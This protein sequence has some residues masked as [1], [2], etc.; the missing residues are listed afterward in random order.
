MF[1]HQIEEI[2]ECS[3]AI[4]AAQREVSKL[5]EMRQEM[6]DIENMIAQYSDRVQIEGYVLKSQIARVI[7]W[8]KSGKYAK[9]D[10][11]KE[12]S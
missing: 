7:E 10:S 5:R 4:E 12:L 11:R 8:T 1:K 9:L 2:R 6:F 3:Q